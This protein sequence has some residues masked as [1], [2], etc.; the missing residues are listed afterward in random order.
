[1]LVFKTFRAALAL[2]G[3]SLLVASVAWEIALLLTLIAPAL[4][5]PPLRLL[6]LLA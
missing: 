2:I 6:L 4:P 1:M 3:A 5:L